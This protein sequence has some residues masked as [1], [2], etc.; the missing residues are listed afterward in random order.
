METHGAETHRAET[1]DVE[2]I[3]AETHGAE[4]HG[5]GPWPFRDTAQKLLCINYQV[6]EELYSRSDILV[7]YVT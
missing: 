1:I 7:P 6:T 3:D 2:T 5:S 4:T